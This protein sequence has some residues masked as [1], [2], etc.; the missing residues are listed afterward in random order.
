MTQTEALLEIAKRD[1]GVI[2]PAA[3]IRAARNPKSVL[4]R[5]FT[6]DD[7]EAAN[8]WRIHEAQHLIRTCYIVSGKGKNRTET[9]AFV[10]LSTDRDGGESANNPY[11]LAHDVAQSEDLLAV[12]EKDALEQLKAVKRRYDHLHRLDKVWEAIDGVSSR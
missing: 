5:A 11:R 4:H 12:A 3:V 10:G 9:Y 2:T 7:T 6:W 1:G 8:K